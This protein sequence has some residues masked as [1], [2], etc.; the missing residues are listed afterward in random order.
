MTAF[1]DPRRLDR[2]VGRLSELSANDWMTDPAPGLAAL[3]SPALSVHVTVEHF[4]EKTGE[5]RPMRAS[6][7]FAPTQPGRPTALLLWSP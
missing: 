5:A 6:F 1:L 3:K 2:L 7:A 4:D